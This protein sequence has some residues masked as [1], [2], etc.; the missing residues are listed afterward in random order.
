MYFLLVH[1]HSDTTETCESLANGY[2]TMG[3]KTCH[4]PFDPNERKKETGW[5]MD[6]YLLAVGAG[7]TDP[8]TPSLVAH[9]D[10]S[11]IDSKFVEN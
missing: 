11:P 8:C 7:T 2:N 9:L 3:R 5:I 6:R 10:N 4:I 1:D